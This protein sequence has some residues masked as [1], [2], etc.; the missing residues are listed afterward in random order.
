MDDDEWLAQHFGEDGPSA[1]VRFRSAVSSDAQALTELVDAAYRHYVDRIGMLPGPMTQD[2][3]DVIATR[4]TTVAEISGL[5]VGV[6][7]LNRSTG[8]FVIENVAVHPE[9]RGTGLGRALL[10]LA[11]AQARRAGFDVV[12]LFTHEQ[13][14]ESLAIYTKRGYREDERRSQGTFDLVFMSKRLE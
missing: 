2:Y 7:V 5:L 8:Q 11:E 3:A 6:L 9:H 1:P 13:M 10:D 14:T 12:H 4:Q